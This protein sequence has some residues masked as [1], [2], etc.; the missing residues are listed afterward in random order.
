L[1]AAQLLSEQG[2]DAMVIDAR[3]VKPLDRRG[4]KDAAGAADLI[5]TIEDNVLSG[6]FGTA[7]REMLEREL[8]DCTRLVSIGLPDDFIRHGAVALLRESCGLTA[9]R[10]AERVGEE[11]ER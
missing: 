5:I 10:I 11:L 4:I 1:G 7:V 3:F 9:S 6:G 8:P 2:V